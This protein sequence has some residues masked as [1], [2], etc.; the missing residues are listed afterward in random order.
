[1]ETEIKV[2][3]VIYNVYGDFTAYAP[4]FPGII[5]Q[6]ETREEVVQKITEKL[7]RMALEDR[8]QYQFELN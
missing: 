5:A 7:Y 1:M 6:G 4:D 8:K 3:I 2:S